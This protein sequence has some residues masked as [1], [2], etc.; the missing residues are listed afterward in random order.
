MTWGQAILSPHEHEC[1]RHA[2]EATV[3]RSPRGVTLHAACGCTAVVTRPDGPEGYASI[4]WDFT[5]GE[6]A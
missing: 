2:R 5:E 1:P 6:Q 3:K 4:A